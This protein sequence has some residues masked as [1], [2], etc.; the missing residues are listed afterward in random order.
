[1]R[2]TVCALFR[3]I[4]K[5]DFPDSKFTL[6]FLGYHD[7]SEIP[8]D[9]K[10][11]VGSAQQDSAFK[12]NGSNKQQCLDTTVRNCCGMCSWLLVVV[13]QVNWMFQQP[14]TLELTH[15][16]GSE[17]D[18]DAKMHNGNDKPQGYGHIG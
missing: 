11:R 12:Q 9:R 5:L 18:P 2:Q 4:E 15:N 17:S 6:Y 8:E 13:L 3:L 14:A 1:M 16:W 10:E 7:A